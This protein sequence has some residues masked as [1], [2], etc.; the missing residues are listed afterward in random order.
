MIVVSATHFLL[1]G[2]DIDAAIFRLDG[3]MPIFLFKGVGE[4]I[5]V[6]IQVN[7]CRPQPPSTVDPIAYRL[8]LRCE[9]AEFFH[10]DIA[11][12]DKG[13]KCSL[14]RSDSCKC[15]DLE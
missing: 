9:T 10:G 15:P 3:F 1:Q 14:L 5:C 2:P 12:N 13:C 4:S 6:K 11:D 8:T 7:S